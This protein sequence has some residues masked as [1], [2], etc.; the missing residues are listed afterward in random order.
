MKHCQNHRIAS[1]I[2]SDYSH[3]RRICNDFETKNLGENHDLYLFKSD[4]LRVAD[5][6]ENFKKICSEIYQLGHE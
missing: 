5:V 1:I 2:E 6:F 3:V 4:A